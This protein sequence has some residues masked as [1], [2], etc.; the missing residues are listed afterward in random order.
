MKPGLELLPFQ[1][2]GAE[3]LAQSRR[4][5]L[6]WDP[7]IGKTPT[8]VRA[9]LLASAVR[10]LVFCP[11]IGTAVWRQHFQDWSDIRGIRIA[12]P[13][14]QN[15]PYD[16]VNG[17]GVRIIPFS[18]ARSEASVIA[19]ASMRPLGRRDHRRGALP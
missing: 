7:G 15:R 11:P 17:E 13:D 2:E 14:D 4:A 9:C 1:K 5:M 16:F 19:V 18:R 6:V 8:A 10:I 12:G 3:L